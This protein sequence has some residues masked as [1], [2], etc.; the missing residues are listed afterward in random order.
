LLVP[1]EE[2]VMGAPDFGA[3]FVDGLGALVDDVG[4]VGVLFEGDF[5]GEVAV[6]DG[7]NRN[8]NDQ[9]PNPNQIPNSKSQGG[10]WNSE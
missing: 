5:E 7:G 3:E 2:P 8:P 1:P 9:K 4:G 10:G 6:G